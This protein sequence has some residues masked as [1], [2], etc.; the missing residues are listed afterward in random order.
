MSDALAAAAHLRTR[1]NV[2]PAR[3]GVLG[4]SWGASAALRTSSAG[5]RRGVP[6]GGFR[7]AAAYDPLC[8]SGRG[9]LPR[10]A[11]ERSTNLLPDIEVPTLILMGADDVDTPSVAQ[12]CSIAVGVA[13][14]AGQ[15]VAIE[16]Y[17]GAGHVFDMG[18]SRPPQAAAKAM[19]DLL[20]FFSR[21][22]GKGG[23]A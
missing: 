13:R 23:G 9:D 11:Q 10:D 8:M 12:N 21:H 6:G 18:P 1:P 19:N 17:P 4:F 22:L 5:Y 2:D 15:P 3:I 16:L 7:A 14:R 20:A